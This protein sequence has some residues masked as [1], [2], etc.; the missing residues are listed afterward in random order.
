[1]KTV[2]LLRH[3]KSAWGD[4][5]VTDHDRPLN[6]RGKRAAEV[7]A[8][9]LVAKAPRPDLILCSTA[10]R[11]RQT[12]AALMERQ[13]PPTP[14]VVFE[15]GLYLASED[16]LLDRLRAL[17]GTIG[18]VLMI[19][20]NDGMGQL[21]NALAA[22]GR[23]AL[24]ASLRNGFPTGALAV[25]TIEVERWTALQTGAATLSAFARPRDLD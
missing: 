13:P 23:A 16:A 25:L 7:M 11:T 4:A 2:L 17:P 12:L 24:L 10:T 3:A 5:G 1:V 9:Y 8:N 14:P 21:A 19:G 18:T 15:S 22:H 6:P 20:H